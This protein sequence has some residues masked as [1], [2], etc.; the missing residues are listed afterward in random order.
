MEF[1]LQ[2]DE[3]STALV[4]VFEGRNIA[5][6][7]SVRKCGALIH[8]AIPKSKLSYSFIPCDRT[9]NSTED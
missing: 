8:T 7:S 9:V 4:F 2:L 1:I 3:E 5:S 6:Y